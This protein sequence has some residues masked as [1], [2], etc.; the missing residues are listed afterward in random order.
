MSSHILDDVQRVCET[1]SIVHRG[2]VRATDTVAAL[3]ARVLRPRL[4]LDVLGPVEGV[5]AGLAAA[6]WAGPV[7]AGEG[8]RLEVEV[9]DTDAAARALPGLLAAA[10]VGLRRLEPIEP[11][12]ETAFLRIV[13]EAEG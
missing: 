3:R 8:G 5:V 13:A 4:R 10:G 6:R 1:V 12:L 2:R 9:T 11:D 7:E